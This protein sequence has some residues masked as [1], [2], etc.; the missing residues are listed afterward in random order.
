MLYKTL[1]MPTIQPCTVLYRILYC[2][3]VYTVLLFTV[4]NMLWPGFCNA[5]GE[6]SKY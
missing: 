3:F 5:Y 1:I 2:V 6:Y 4:Y